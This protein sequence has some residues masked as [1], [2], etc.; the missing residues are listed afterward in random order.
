MPLWL[1]YLLF[2]IIWVALILS[3]PKIAFCMVWVLNKS[4]LCFNKIFIIKKLFNE[5]R[6]RDVLD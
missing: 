5:V 6:D 2:A 3:V 1:F 4:A